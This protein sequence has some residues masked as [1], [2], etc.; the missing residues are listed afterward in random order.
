MGETIS[1]KLDCL[2]GLNDAGRGPKISRFLE[3]KLL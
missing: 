1:S 3:L 2:T